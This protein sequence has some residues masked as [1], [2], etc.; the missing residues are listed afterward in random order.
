MT[1]LQRLTT[2]YVET[3][4]RFRIS[5]EGL[6]GELISL[7][8]TQRLM[9]RLIPYLVSTFDKVPA[10]TN[11]TKPA[12]ESGSK[13]DAA[14]NKLYNELYNEMSQQAA[15]QQIVEQPPVINA[16][17]SNVWLVMEID[18]SKSDQ[19]VQMTF[20]NA[21]FTPV[22]VTLDQNQLRQWLAI[23]YKLWQ[24][25]EWPIDVWPAWIQNSAQETTASATTSVH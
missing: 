16:D 24:Q 4:D 5:G 21:S 9:R 15:Q 22:H 3:E 6:E 20:K 14:G 23:V 19:I 1:S 8:N 10:A 25:A 18:V 17:N 12:S 2:E 11:T 7:W 13:G